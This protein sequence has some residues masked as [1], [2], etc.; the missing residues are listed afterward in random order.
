M[1]KVWGIGCKDVNAIATPQVGGFLL[2][3]EE[4]H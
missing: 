1:L 3:D 4:D 2:D